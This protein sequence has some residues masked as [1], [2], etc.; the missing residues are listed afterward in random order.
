MTELGRILAAE[1]GWYEYRH[2][3]QRAFILGIGLGAAAAVLVLLRLL[4]RTPVATH[5]SM[6]GT[7]ALLAFVVVRASSMHHVDLIIRSSLW[8]IRGNWVIEIGGILVVL[9]GACLR[10]YQLR[11]ASGKPRPALVEA[12]R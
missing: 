1:Q 9:M 2:K 8:G 12:E 5:L 3:V 4:R 10:L 11:R 6:L 7:V